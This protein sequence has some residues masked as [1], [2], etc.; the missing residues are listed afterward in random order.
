MTGTPVAGIP[1]VG[2]PNPSTGV[3]TGAS[4]FTDPAGRTLTY[5]APTPAPVAA[6]S[7]STPDRGVHLHPDR[8]P[9]QTA[10]ATTTDTFTVT[11]TNGTTRATETITVPVD[12]GDPGRRH[13]HRGHPERDTGAVTG[14][15]AFTDPAGRT[16]SY[17]A[18]TTSTG[19]GTVSIN[20]TTGA[21]TYTP[22]QAQRQAAT[23]TT[24]DT[25]TVTANNG[26]HR[27]PK[28]SPS[29]SQQRPRQ[30]SRLSRARQA[31]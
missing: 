18:P 17:S 22:T 8:G 23:G 21:Y 14:T 6:R 20:T 7:P 26:V 29:Q 19:G 10:T 25:F 1:I 27:P 11:A 2:T 31:W 13:P 24:T 16:L 30:Q 15:A 9:T 3:V 12:A 4:V 5:S 28:R